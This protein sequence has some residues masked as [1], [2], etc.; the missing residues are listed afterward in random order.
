MALALELPCVC[1]ARLCGGQC[2]LPRLVGFWAQVSRFNH[3]PLGRVGIARH[4]GLHRLVAQ[5]NLDRQRPCVCHRR[6]LWRLHGGLDECACEAR[7]LPSLRVSRRLLRLGGHVL[8]R[9]LRLA[10]ARVGWVVLERHAEGVVAKP[11]R[12]CRQHENP[13]IGDS[14]RQRLSGAR[15]ARLGLLQHPQ[16]QRR[17]R[18]FAVVPR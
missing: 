6:Q 8:R 14:W 3:A 5:K 12:L 11:A 13:H 9:C 15:C 16:S 18:A 2:Q 10:C 4:G 7:S 1:C 17:G